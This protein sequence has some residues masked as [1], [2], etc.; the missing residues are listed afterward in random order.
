MDKIVGQHEIDMAVNIRIRSE[1]FMIATGVA[2]A[3]TSEKKT[4]LRWK[5]FMKLVIKQNMTAIHHKSCTVVVSLQMVSSLQAIQC[6]SC[7]VQ[8]VHGSDQKP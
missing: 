6:C 3:D 5:A 7:C 4:G 8:W 1:I 2:F